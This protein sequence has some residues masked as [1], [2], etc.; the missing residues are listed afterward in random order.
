MQRII[1]VFILGYLTVSLP[2]AAAS[3]E[4]SSSSFAAANKAFNEGEYGRA[5]ALFEAAREA[6]SS[7]PAIYYNIGVC[8]Y[9]LGNYADAVRAF[10]N[11]ARDYPAMRGLAQYNLGLVRLRQGR[12]HAA[13]ELFEQAKMDR[14]DAKVPRLAEAMLARMS[15]S[16][17]TA[18]EAP[19]WI[20][21]ADI[22]VG[23]DDNVALI[24]ESNLPAGQAVDS[25]FTEVVAVL[26]GP[27]SS[28][29]GLRFDG[30]LY[31][32]R[33][34][35]ADDYDQTAVR[36]RGVYAWRNGSWEVEAG[37]QFGY[38]TLNGDGFE[39]R[40]GAR[41]RA[42]HDLGSSLTLGVH[43]VH[44]EINDAATQFAY[45]EGSQDAI[46]VSLDRY[47]GDGRLTFGY[48]IELNDRAGPGV[49]ANRD[50]VSLRYR[51][52]M[53]SKWTGDI[54]MAYRASTYDELAVTRNE[55][56]AEFSLGLERVLA[57]GWQVRGNFRWYDNTSNVDLYSYTRSRLV[58]G[59]SKNF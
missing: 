52:V 9:R 58:V 38:S 44:D 14:K 37:P 24:D 33:Y 18:E 15:S 25:A 55:D 7:G 40:L 6:G 36:L 1:I 12:D 8:H 32:I 35:D 41:L 10:T 45:V 48:D 47:I 46:G 13:R 29:P 43:V 11:L 54:G 19:T 57:Q 5:L 17:R 30:S 26:S 27:L 22:N 31:S 28:E 39:Q 2:I 3:A 53:S 21:V 23:H 51:Q 49:S 20:S 50:R 4:D 42:R 16:K 34:D 56:R 59:L